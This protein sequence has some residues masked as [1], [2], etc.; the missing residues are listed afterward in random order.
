[1]STNPDAIPYIYFRSADRVV[2]VI[3]ESLPWEGFQGEIDFFQFH[4]DRFAKFL[5]SEVHSSICYHSDGNSYAYAAGKIPHQHQGVFCP[6]L[7]PLKE[8]LN[9]VG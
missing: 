2:T 6:S 8:L 1:M 7:V 3:G 9:E 5:E 4:A